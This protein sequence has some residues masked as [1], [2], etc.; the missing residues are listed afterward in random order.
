[1]KGWRKWF[2]ASK[3]L[4]QNIEHFWRVNT[5]SSHQRCSIGKGVLKN[6]TNLTGNT[7]ARVSFLIKLHPTSDF[8][9]GVSCESWEI[10]KNTFFYRTP[11]VAA[12]IIRIDLSI[13]LCFAPNTFTVLHLLQYK[14]LS[15]SYTCTLVLPTFIQ[16][17]DRPT[18]FFSLLTHLVFLS[19]EVEKWSHLLFLWN[20]L[21]NF[22]GIYQ[23]WF[24]NSSMSPVYPEPSKTRFI[25]KA[26]SF[27]EI[28]LG[29]KQETI[30]LVFKVKKKTKQNWQNVF[31]I[32]F[33]G[34]PDLL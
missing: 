33:S 15:I 13:L 4:A 31:K 6:F 16:G 19:I 29:V 7:C 34:N 30:N 23:A 20:S 9:A 14:K 22:N 3:D 26:F 8:G 12:S 17:R 21:S 2:L 10:F 11:L 24:S 25:W 32:Y 27:L 5:R 1:M 18:S 28:A